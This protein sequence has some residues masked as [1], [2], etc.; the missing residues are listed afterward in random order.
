M[1]KYMTILFVLALSLLM[2]GCDTTVE[3]PQNTDDPQAIEDMQNTNDQSNAKVSSEEPAGD[4]ALQATNEVMAEGE[5]KEI[6]TADTDITGFFI[7]DGK[8]E[9]IVN[10][11]NT[12][13]VNITEE[14]KI[15]NQES[16]EITVEELEVGMYV[17]IVFYG[18]IA[19]S[20]PPQGSAGIINIIK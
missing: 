6:Y 16:N 1:K 3:E 10:K 2:I 15:F 5:I 8:T 18:S 13:Y 4:L 14:T 19:E 11:Y 12:A 7:A 20:Y 17:E 9:G